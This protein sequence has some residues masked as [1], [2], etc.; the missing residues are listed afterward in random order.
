MPKPDAADR[1]VA[2]ADA[3]VVLQVFGDDVSISTD[4][5]TGD[6]INLLLEVVD[7]I[8]GGAF[9]DRRIGRMQ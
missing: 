6:L 4:M 3:S 9:T 8:E 1:A 7:V 2:T 5:E